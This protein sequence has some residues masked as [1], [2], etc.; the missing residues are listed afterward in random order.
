[1]SESE[2]YTSIVPLILFDSDA[3]SVEFSEELRL[4]RTEPSELSKLI[5]R[6]SSDVTPYLS[7]LNANY[8]LENKLVPPSMKYWN[9]VIIALKLL[10]L[11][12]LQVL[13]AFDLHEG[14][15]ISLSVYDDLNRTTL[16][17]NPYFLRK[18]ETTDLIGLWERVQEITSKPFLTFPLRVFTEAYHKGASY[19]DRIVDYMVA[20][21]SLIFHGMDKSIE[22]AGEVMGIAVGMLLGIDQ[23]DRTKIKMTLKN[24]Y[25]VRNAKVHGNVAR[26]KKLKAKSNVRLLSMDVEDYLRRALRR[27]VEE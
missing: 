9:D 21:E 27:F 6:L 18:E 13:A 10:K 11:G 5:D 4:R 8:V 23:E 12:D 24:A 22:P 19:D 15:R 16:A 20:F 17:L 7:L 3:E 2:K 26:L 14:K 25:E 1:M